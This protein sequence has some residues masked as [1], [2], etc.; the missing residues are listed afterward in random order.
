D[1]KGNTADLAGTPFDCAIEQGPELVQRADRDPEQVLDPVAGD[2]QEGFVGSPAGVRSRRRV[3]VAGR[4]VD[5]RGPDV[6]R[7]DPTL[8]EDPRELIDAFIVFAQGRTGGRG[9]SDHPD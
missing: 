1:P 3:V 8:F 5:L 2:P 6:L 7:V 4:G 9:R